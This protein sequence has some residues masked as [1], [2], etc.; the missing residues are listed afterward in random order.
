[1][2]QAWSLAL[3]NCHLQAIEWAIEQQVDIISISWAVKKQSFE[4]QEAI[5]KAVRT[6]K[7]L[8]F[9]ST[10]DIGSQ[11]HPDVYPANYEDVIAV[12]ASNRFGWARLES[13]RDV[14]IMLGGEK[15]KA[16]GPK[17]MQLPDNRISGSSVA[18]ALAAGLASL[19]LFLARMA[20]PNGD[21]QHFKNRIAM[22]HVF[23]LMQESKDNRVIVPAKLFDDEFK[24]PDDFHSGRHPP[25]VGLKRFNWMMIS[26]SIQA[27]NVAP[28][29]GNYPRRAISEE[30]HRLRTAAAQ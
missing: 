10:A 3:S 1:V 26:G 29:N 27:N 19:C 30:R 12:S 11:F 28:F 7:I 24:L 9:C 15:I 14:H 20:N 21:G 18:T 22:L 4:L 16:H 5:R 23:R 25:P 8:V 2:Q 13:C 6:H 17:Y